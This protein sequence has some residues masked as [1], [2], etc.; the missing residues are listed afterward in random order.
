VTPTIIPATPELLECFYGRPQ[1]RTV[2]A[3]AAV[4]GD[5]PVCVAGTF[6]E[7]GHKVAFAD[8]TPRMRRYPKTGLRMA[9]SVMQMIRA[10]GVPVV[11]V[12]D[13]HIEPARRFL[14]FLGFEQIRDE[15][16]SWRA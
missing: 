12:A 2:C 3:L 15:V 16:Y 9:R 4:V 11:A 8:V 6:M 14:E 7:R 13:T 10:A 1:Q 5:E